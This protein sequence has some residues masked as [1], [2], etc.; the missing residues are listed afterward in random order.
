MILANLLTVAVFW[1]QF[2]NLS[3]FN[4]AHDKGTEGYVGNLSTTQ[5]F[6]GSKHKTVLSSATVSSCLSPTSSRLYPH[7]NL[8]QE[9]QKIREEYARIEKNKINYQVYTLFKRSSDNVPFLVDTSKVEVEEDH[10]EYFFVHANEPYSTDKKT[11]L[12]FDD[13]G[14]LR[15]VEIQHWDAIEGSFSY[16]R[17]FYFAQGALQAFFVYEYGNYYVGAINHIY[18]YRLY[19]EWEA[20]VTDSC[21]KII[22]GLHRMIDGTNIH[23]IET[24]YPLENKNLNKDD[25]AASIKNFFLTED[26][27]ALSKIDKLEFN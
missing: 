10:G 24:V 17:N 22:R 1:L 25:L 27:V 7:E 20:S 19:N 23:R 8:A 3:D 21:P 26:L 4:A 15:F 18:E 6:G 16:S 9:I 2:V 5:Q 12:S 14:D 13:A 11:M